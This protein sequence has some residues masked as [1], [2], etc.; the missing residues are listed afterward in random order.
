MHDAI[1]P[2]RE[3][4]EIIS[5]REMRDV[6]GHVLYSAATIRSGS[7]PRMVDFFQYGAGSST[8]WADA[9]TRADTNM[10]QAAR[11]PAPEEFLIKRLGVLPAQGFPPALAAAV[12]SDSALE[13]YL[14]QK[15]YWRLPTWAMMVAGDAPELA[16]LQG[17][18]YQWGHV[19]PDMPIHIAQQQNFFARLL[20]P[21]LPGDHQGFKLWVLL[22]GKISRS[23]I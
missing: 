22:E 3:P 6:S 14:G 18:P 20:L 10:W 11:L 12:L 15:N 16:A 5:A 2:A 23:V 9:A 19:Q 1:T 4:R 21:E 13:F 8:A 17:F 7:C